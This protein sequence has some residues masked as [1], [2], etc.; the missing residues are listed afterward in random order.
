MVAHT[1]GDFSFPSK[2]AAKDFARSILASARSGMSLSGEQYLFAASLLEAHP[3][4]IEK[5]GPGVAAIVAGPN[6]QFGSTCF[7]VVRTDGTREDFSFITAIDGEK[8]KRSQVLHAM[9][10]EIRPQIWAWRRRQ[11]DD[12]PQVCAM[13]GVPVQ[14]GSCHVDHHPLAF[15]QIAS[16]VATFLGG[17]DSV[18]VQ[19]ETWALTDPHQ[20]SVW[21]E[22]HQTRVVDV[23]GLRLLTPRANLTRG[24]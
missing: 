12:G 22:V 18:E 2:K 9:R 5:I 3:D 17:W 1:I 16:F 20:R 4:S 19:R 21:T 6:P 11:F 14:P 24:A 8:D 7:F 13:T 10:A 23:D 15:V